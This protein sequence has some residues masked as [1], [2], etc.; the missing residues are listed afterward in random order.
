MQHYIKVVQSLSV[1]MI[2]GGRG[3][4]GNAFA[5]QPP[6]PIRLYD[7]EASPFCRRVREVLTLLNLDVEIYPC[8][9]EGTRFRPEAIK[10]AGKAQFP[11]L[12]DENTGTQLLESQDI[13]DYL[14]KTYGKTGKTPKKWQNL[15]TIPVLGVLASLVGGLRGGKAAAIHANRVLPAQKLELWGFE[16]SPFTRLVR[17]RLCELELPYILHQ[18]AKERWQD[19]GPAVLRAKPGPYEPVKG[20]KR[21]Q[22]LT[23]M[24]GRMQVPFLVDPNTDTNLFESAA[25]IDYLNK[26][27][28]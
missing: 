9:K 6:L 1:S 13:I 3:I 18:V 10:L 17:E 26:H 5:T 8:P 4:M 7:I 12:V 2:E 22:E 15:P 27:Y 25:I 21:E 23:K 20:G 14:F 11:F 28:A 16:A 19:M 24:H